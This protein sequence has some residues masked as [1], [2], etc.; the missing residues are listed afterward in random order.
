MASTT[1]TEVM[2]RGPTAT[3]REVK[4]RF[5]ARVAENPLIDPATLS[6]ERI[7]EISGCRALARWFIDPSVEAW[8]RNKDSA[9]HRIEAGVEVAVRRLVEILEDTDIGPKGRVTAAAQVNAAKLLLE[10]AGYAP[11]SRRE[12]VFHDKEIHNMDEKKLR[13]YI[14]SNVRHLAP[15]EKTDGDETT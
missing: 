2:E 7:V 6:V 10:Y 1:D 4:A 5:W 8:F 9:R 14:D 11:P 15:A 3:Q 13:A 12:V